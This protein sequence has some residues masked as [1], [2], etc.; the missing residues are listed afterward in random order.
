MTSLSVFETPNPAFAS[1]HSLGTPVG[2]AAK[3]M[4][5][6]CPLPPPLDQVCHLY[7]E[8]PSRYGRPTAGSGP[9]PSGSQLPRTLT[10]LM[11][12]VWVVPEVVVNMSVF[13]FA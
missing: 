4:V 3:R 10:P 6:G 12:S 11:V 2:F 5:Q 9:V 1:V 8:A 7:S 13:S